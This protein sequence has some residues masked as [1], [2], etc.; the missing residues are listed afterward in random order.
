MEVT[1][2][3]H[4]ELRVETCREV[5]E[6]LS[7]DDIVDVEEQIGDTLSIF[8]HKEASELDR[9]EA[10]GADVVVKARVPA[11]GACLSPYMAFCSTQT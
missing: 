8:V 3:H 9:S 6:P 5:L 4:G 1:E 10:N 2:I 11:R 7:V